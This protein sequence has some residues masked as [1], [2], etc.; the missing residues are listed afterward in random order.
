[1][2]RKIATLSITLTRL[3]TLCL[4][5]V[6]PMRR[7][8]FSHGY[9]RW[10]H[11]HGIV[12]SQSIESQVWETGSL[13]QRNFGIGSMVVAVESPV[14]RPCFA[15]ELQGSVRPTSGKRLYLSLRKG[16]FKKL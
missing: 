2:L 5:L 12:I 11:A 6:V 1:M 10:N 7:L 15:T 14:I 16:F 3:I 8:R 13:K 9:L 4:T